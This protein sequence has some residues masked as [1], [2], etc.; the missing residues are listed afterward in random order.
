MAQFTTLTRTTA[1]ATVYWTATPPP[2]LA[3][4][5]L[6]YTNTP[7]ASYETMS[8]LPTRRWDETAPWRTMTGAVIGAT[9]SNGQFTG[10]VDTVRF[11][12]TTWKGDYL[13][14][15]RTNYNPNFFEIWPATEIVTLYPSHQMYE[16]S[17]ILTHT[18]TIDHIVCDAGFWCEPMHGTTTL[19]AFTGITE[20]PLGPTWFPVTTMSSEVWDVYEV[21][22][23]SNTATIAPWLLGVILCIVVVTLSGLLF[24]W[25]VVLRRERKRAAVRQRLRRSLKEKKAPYEEGDNDLPG[26]TA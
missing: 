23:D 7:P 4:S 5:P 26:Y 20:A 15:D 1:Y 10:A 9:D 2:T 22:H 8:S 13:N 6:Y 14:F 11:S 24:I 3:V 16:Y 25:L 21:H 17:N 19:T 12:A 18:E